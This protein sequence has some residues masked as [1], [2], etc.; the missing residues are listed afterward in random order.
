[1][2]I[3]IIRPFIRLREIVA[4]NKDTAVLAIL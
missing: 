1:M 3:F 2:S 4:H